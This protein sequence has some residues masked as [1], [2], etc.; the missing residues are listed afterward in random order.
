MRM[1]SLQEQLHQRLYGDSER[2]ILLNVLS[3]LMRLLL[4]SYLSENHE[5]VWFTDLG[6]G[7][8]TQYPEIKKI[9]TDHHECPP[10]SDALVSF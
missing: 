7:I 3:S 5:L 6:S 10:D 2:N 9:I 4:I 8:S 1:G